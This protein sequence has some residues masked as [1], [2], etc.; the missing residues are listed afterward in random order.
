MGVTL[1]GL[2]RRRIGGLAAGAVAVSTV[3]LTLVASLAASSPATAAPPPGTT[4]ACNYVYEWIGKIRFPLQPD[5]HAVYSAVFPSD[6]AGQDGVGF[7]VR[8]E[9]PHAVWTSWATYTGRGGPFSVTNFV[10]NPPKNSNNPVVADA[11][12]IDPFT[13][14]QLMQGTPRNFTLLFTP[15]GYAGTTA[16][17]LAGVPTSS[18]NPANTKPYPVSSNTGGFWLLANRVYVSFPGYNP[19]G[20]TESTFPTV[21]AVDLATGAEVDCQKYNVA[22]DRLQGLPTN[23]PDALKYGKSPTRIVLKNGSVWIG[24]DGSQSGAGQF[25]PPNPKGLVLFTRPKALPGGDLATIPPPDNCSGYLGTSMNPGAISLIRIPHIANY[26]DGL[27]V[28]SSSTYP[29]PVNP[30]EEWEAS[31]QSLVQYGAAT[32]IYKPGS[33]NTATV[34][35]AEFKVDPSGGSTILVWPRTLRGAAKLRMFRYARRQG[36]AIVRGGQQGRLTGANMLMR[37]KAPASDYFGSTSAV[38]CYFGTPQ[39]PENSDLE[40]SEVPIESGSRFIATAENMG[41]PGAKGGIISAAP[42]GV[43]CSSVRSLTS[44]RCVA[45]LKRYIKSTGGSYTAPSR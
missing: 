34:A 18:I 5:P 14:G 33:P 24:S 22:P 19:G 37:V 20:S 17:T 43:T 21:K 28:T 16:P 4:N 41:T 40:W 2:S 42:Q 38:P 39:N 32:G 9:F 25:S 12:S 45:T 30:G 26:T 1:L 35:D 10:N 23:P 36:W 31:Y 15:E 11:G 6:Q 3:A 7:L 29:N 13:N 44:G 8:G 27:K